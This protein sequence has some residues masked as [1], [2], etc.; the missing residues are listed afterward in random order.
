MNALLF[1]WIRCLGC[2]PGLRQGG[3]CG[4]V[5][6]ERGGKEKGLGKGCLWDTLLT[7]RRLLP[8]KVR[9]GGC[10]L[11]ASRLHPSQVGAMQW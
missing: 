4:L 8:L 2:F 3:L 9:T 6:R 5:G 10:C 7:N 11:S 1:S